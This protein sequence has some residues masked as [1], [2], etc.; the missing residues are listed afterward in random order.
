MLPQATADLYVDQQRRIVSALL[1][2]RREWSK[3]GTDF[4]A[5]WATVGPR[6]TLLTASAQ[7][8]AA[9][10]GAL[11]VPAVLD[12]LGQSVDPVGE[13]R[14]EG[15]AGVASD[16]RP[17][18]TLLDGAV[19]RSKESVKQGASPAD[20]LLK[21]GQWLDMAVH[22]MIADAGREAAG[23]AIA[24]RPQVG[25]V[26]M[27]NPP[28]CSRCAI[29]SG[30]WFKWNQGFIRHPRCDCYHIPA[31]EH[32]GELGW[33]P[34]DL[35]KEGKVTGVTKAGQQ[36]IED[37]ADAIAVIN[38]TGRHVFDPTT[39]KYRRTQSG[40][41]TTEGTTRRGYASYIK[42][43]LAKQRGEIAKETAT[44]VGQRGYIKQYKVRRTGPRPT[45]AAIYKYATSREDAIQLL[46]ANGYIVGGSIRDVAARAL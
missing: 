19:V 14:P 30:K 10:A 15:F 20:A 3:M 43:E 13:V 12:E 17:L 28:C 22:T 31:P 7:L 29:L 23:V 26:R 24:A 2:T 21:G 39:G 36:A 6:V 34:D 4:D 1:L 32:T 27:V 18:D 35:I 16:G 37:G 5:S 40:M 11:M 42:R 9:R 46:A 33:A 45:P 25:W 44:K 38:A 41:F 8:G